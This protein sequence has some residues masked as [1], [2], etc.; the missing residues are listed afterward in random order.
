M[1]IVGAEALKKKPVVSTVANLLLDNR[2][3]GV[4]FRKCVSLFICKC[5][6][7]IDKKATGLFP[8]SGNSD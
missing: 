1:A 2:C 4:G 5:L 8:V 6:S 3:P 7:G